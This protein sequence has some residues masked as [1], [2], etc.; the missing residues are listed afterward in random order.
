MVS[1]ELILHLTRKVKFCSEELCERNYQNH[2]L[3]KHPM[4]MHRTLDRLVL[5]D[6]HLRET[7][8]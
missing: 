7:S 8:E 6:I 4:K 5:N 2:L 1:K 3:R